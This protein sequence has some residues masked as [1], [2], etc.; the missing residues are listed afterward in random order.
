MEQKFQVKGSF[1]EPEFTKISIKTFLLIKLKPIVNLE[2]AFNVAARNLQKIDR[3]YDDQDEKAK[4]ITEFL[5][6][7]LTTIDFYIL[8]MFNYLPHYADSWK[9]FNL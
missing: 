9:I 8:R 4:H 6:K 1:F 2:K 5:E 3:L 7:R